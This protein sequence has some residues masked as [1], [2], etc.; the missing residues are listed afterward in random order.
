MLETFTFDLAELIHDPH[1][2][3]LL[4]ADLFSGSPSSTG[5]DAFSTL[6]LALLIS[7]FVAISLPTVSVFS[8]QQNKKRKMPINKAF[9]SAPHQKVIFFCLL[10]SNRL[11]ECIEQIVYIFC[12]TSK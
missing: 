11:L 4:P 2:L 9:C 12:I 3:L 8:L 7:S 1:Q 6:L 5:L 10:R